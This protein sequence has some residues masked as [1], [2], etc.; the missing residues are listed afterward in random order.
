MKEILD[1]ILVLIL[2]CDDFCLTIHAIAMLLSILVL[3]SSNQR[4]FSTGQF[5]CVSYEVQMWDSLL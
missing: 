2:F 5:L 3:L 4:H 1:S